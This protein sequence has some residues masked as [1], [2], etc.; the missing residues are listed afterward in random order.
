VFGHYRL[1]VGIIA[2][3]VCLDQ[4]SKAFATMSLNDGEEISILGQGLTF[5]LR[6][7]PGVAWGLGAS[8]PVLVQRVAFPALAVV[9]GV[10]LVAYYRKIPSED[11]IRKGAV[12]LIL[13]GG[14]GNLIDRLRVG[15]VV[16]FIAIDLGVSR[17]SMAGTFNLADVW[18]VCGVAVMVV[19]MFVGEK[20]GK[21]SMGDG[22]SP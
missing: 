20:R 5:R 14:L 15:A 8:T 6:S 3:A 7:N 2:L 16:D 18:M 21:G 11:T 17:W 22:G 12:A 4:G 10:I 19:M 13:G 1:L 9:V